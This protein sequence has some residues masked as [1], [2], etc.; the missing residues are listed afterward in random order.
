MRII[1]FDIQGLAETNP[2]GLKGDGLVGAYQKEIGRRV[3]QAVRRAYPITGSVRLLIE[4]D[5]EKFECG[6]ELLNFPRIERDS[7]P[8]RK[9]LSVYLEDHD[10]D[11]YREIVSVCEK[12]AV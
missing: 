6:R 8:G 7:K 4:R 3:Y 5:I 2:L 11:L 1:K 9:S 10:E 12:V